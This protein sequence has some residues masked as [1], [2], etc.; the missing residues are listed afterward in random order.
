[1]E[2][3]KTDSAVNEA[4]KFPSLLKFLPEQKRAIEYDYN[5]I[6]THSYICGGANYLEQVESTEYNNCGINISK[7][8]NNNGRD[9]NY[10]Y[11][12]N[13]DNDNNDINR[14]NNQIYGG[15][16]YV[17]QKR[18]NVDNNKLKI[19]SCANMQ[20][21]SVAKIVESTLQ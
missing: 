21:I 18:S 9:D 17:E 3:N 7:I 1:M 16:Y 6:K 14:T 4:D 19:E 13:N 8:E 15:V 5:N 2:I 10:Y 11:N 12:N 20:I